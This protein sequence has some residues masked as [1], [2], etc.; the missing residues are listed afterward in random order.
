MLH[1]VNWT[2]GQISKWN[3]LWQRFFKEKWTKQKSA[4]T[5]FCNFKH[6]KHL[7]AHVAPYRYSKQPYI[8]KLWKHFCANKIFNPYF[9]PFFT[10][11]LFLRCDLC[12]RMVKV[13]LPIGKCKENFVVATCCFALLFAFCYFNVL[14]GILCF[15]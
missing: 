7:Q 2:D 4:K 6:L 1:L 13:E 12:F 14:I 9:P 11:K 5:I 8:N 10:L 15:Y 3:Y